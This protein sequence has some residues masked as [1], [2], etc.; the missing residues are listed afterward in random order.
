[1]SRPNAFQAWLNQKTSEQK[2]ELRDLVLSAQTC[3]LAYQ[4]IRKR[5]FRGSY[6]SVLNFRNANKEGS[7]AA[8]AASVVAFEQKLESTQQSASN[9]LEGALLLSV[10]MQSL[11]SKLVGLLASYDWSEGGD[12]LST[13]D[14]LKLAAVIPSIARASTGSLVELFS[15]RKELDYEDFAGSLF[16]ELMIE[17]RLILAETPENL[18]IVESIVECTKT[19]LEMT[20]ERYLAMAARDNQTKTL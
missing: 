10:E 2:T 17:A 7:A 13:R 14:A 15:L 5:G 9:P 4:Q 6:D 1:M 8:I 20:P 3:K 16:E 19:R 12:P 18:P 11:C